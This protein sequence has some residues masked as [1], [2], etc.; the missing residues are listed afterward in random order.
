MSHRL[1]CSRRPVGGVRLAAAIALTL[2]IAKRLQ[3]LLP[4]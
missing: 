3:K 1:F 2:R 4:V